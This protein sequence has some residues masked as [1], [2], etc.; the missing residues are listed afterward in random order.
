MKQLERQKQVLSPL[1]L[2]PVAQSV[3]QQGR[4]ALDVLR[5]PLH[6]PQWTFLYV[7]CQL[8]TPNTVAWLSLEMG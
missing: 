8:G 7:Q 6:K 5:S 1:V 2:N 3:C 4:C